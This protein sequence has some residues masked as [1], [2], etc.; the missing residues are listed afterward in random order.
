M[1]RTC[2]FG[3]RLCG[4]GGVQ[5]QKPPVL[6][7]VSFQSSERNGV[8]CDNSTG[9]GVQSRHAGRPSAE[10]DMRHPGLGGWIRVNWEKMRVV[11]HWEKTESQGKCQTL[12]VLLGE[13]AV[14][15]KAYKG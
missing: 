14:Y 3:A 12:V 1:F 15:L 9:E 5:K 10:P 8:Q 4:E 2:S 6:S 11:I 7:S 13:V